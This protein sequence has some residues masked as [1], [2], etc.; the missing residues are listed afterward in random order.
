M[1][2]CIKGGRIPGSIEFDGREKMVRRSVDECLRVLDGKKDLDVFECA[3]VDPRTP[4]EETIG[5]LAQ[6]VKEGQIK[7]IGRSGS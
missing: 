1:V 5:V 4:I 2:L 3:R 7:G 6:Y